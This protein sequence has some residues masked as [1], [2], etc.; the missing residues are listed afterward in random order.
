MQHK[1]LRFAI[2]LSTLLTSVTPLTADLPVVITCEQPVYSI[3]LFC[4]I[5]ERNRDMLRALLDKHGALLFRD[6]P[7]YNARD[8]SA[9][10]KTLLQ[11]E[12]VDYQC[13]EGS[14]TRVTQGVY[15]STEAAPEFHIPLHHELPLT[16]SPLTYIALFCEIEPLP[17]TGQTLLASTENVSQ[18]I[19]QQPAIWDQY[20]GK[21]LK[22]T[23]RHPPQ[24]SF[25]CAVNPTHKPWQEVFDTE[26]PQVAE[27]I[28]REKGFEYQWLGKWLEVVRWAP[29]IRGPDEHFDHPYWFNEADLY[30]ANPR[31]R[32]CWL[33][34]LLANLLYIVP[35]TRPY[36]VEFDDG[37]PISRD[38]LYT[39]YDILDD[40]TIRVDWQRGDLLILNNIKTLHGKAPHEGQRRILISMIR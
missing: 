27:A 15:T 16:D 13:G 24:G 31:I 4:H 20:D 10:V 11:R 37:S 6:F 23:S 12:P 28:C 38:S 3:D 5:V 30:H 18:R 25:F 21:I 14:R 39:I 2:V 7:I 26:D 19:L 36:E 8:F 22:Y 17:G 9:A 1:I 32:G 35:S 34:H 29:A 40:E 33:N